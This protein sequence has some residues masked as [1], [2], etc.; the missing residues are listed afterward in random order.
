MLTYPLCSMPV[1][2]IKSQLLGRKTD[3][4]SQSILQENVRNFQLFWG[5]K[6]D[7]RIYH[8]YNEE[9]RPFKNIFGT[10][11]NSDNQHFFPF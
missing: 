8:S 9:R 6:I 2:V 4:K 1:L 7:L 3:V 10:R 5:G 11:E